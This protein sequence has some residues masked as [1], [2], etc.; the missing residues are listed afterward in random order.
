MFEVTVICAACNEETA[1]VVE[2]LD[3]VDREV[4]DCGYSF[5]V[6]A[7]AE[8]KQVYGGEGQLIDLP[9][10]SDGLSRAA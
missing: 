6:L 3:D 5:V 1:V 2:N 10:R 8:F 9:R 7:V 4:C